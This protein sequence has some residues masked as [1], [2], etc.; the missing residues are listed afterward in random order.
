MQIVVQSEHLL[1]YAGAGGVYRVGCMWQSAEQN[2][3]RRGTDRH[4]LA[5]PSMRGGC[6]TSIT[7][8]AW[9]SAAALLDGSS[10]PSLLVCGGC[11]CCHAK[12]SLASSK[13][14]VFNKFRS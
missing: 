3:G 6:P 1:L 5:Y 12:P 14:A 11:R 13:L 7:T 10:E 8:T 4:G 2:I 9:L